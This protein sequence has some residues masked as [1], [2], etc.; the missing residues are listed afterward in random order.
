MREGV[1]GP[2]ASFKKKGSSASVCKDP[3]GVGASGR[4][5]IRALMRTLMS[6]P[7]QPVQTPEPAWRLLPVIGIKGVAHAE[8]DFVGSQVL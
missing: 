3:F 8:D 5:L 1:L 6:A 7:T 4:S 2:L